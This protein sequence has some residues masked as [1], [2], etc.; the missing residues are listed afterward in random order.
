MEIFSNREI[1]I[2]IWLAI[3]LT[4]VFLKANLRNFLFLIIKHFFRK[5]ILTSLAF[6]YSY[7][8][9]TVL[10]LDGLQIWDTS[11]IKNT[12]M[13]SIFVGMAAVYKA[14]NNSKGLVFFKEWIIDNLKLIAVLEFIISF[15]VFPLSIEIILQPILMFIAFMGAFSEGKKEFTIVSKL[16]SVVLIVSGLSTFGYVLYGIWSH[17]NKFASIQ[18]F[19][20]FYTPIA[21]SVCLTPFLYFLYVYSS[22]ERIRIGIHFSTDDQKL[23]R[24]MKW[25]AALSFGTDIEFLDRWQRSNFLRKP[26]NKKDVKQSISDIKELKHIEKNPPAVDAREG[27]SPYEAQKFLIKYALVVG[28]YH[29]Q[30]NDEW[31]ARSAS[32]KIGTERVLGNHISY[33]IEGTKRAAKR[34]KLFLNVHY[35]NESKASEEKFM[36]IGCYLFEKISNQNITDEVRQIILLG[37]GELEVAN[38]RI[39]ISKDEWR[40]GY[41]KGI[42]F[43]I[44][45]G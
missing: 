44:W 35:L 9:L 43:E 1:A 5:K 26:V 24:Y 28:D 15:E 32:L 20:D 6:L 41:E 33:H 39:E 27:W 25:K 31:G 4:W 30:F 13:W 18:T 34:L 22:Y 21:L 8:G 19:I 37:A 29:R 3:F 11:Q 7:I 36:E 45:A 12:I 14:T 23:R 17:Y 38:L 42:V 40:D 10:C 2:S 16:C